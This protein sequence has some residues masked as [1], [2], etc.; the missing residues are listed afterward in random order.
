MKRNLLFVIPS[1]SAG[2]GEKSLVNLLSQINF[3]YYNVDLFLFTHDG[4]FMG[5]LPKEVN[6]IN[7]PEDY[8]LFSLPLLYS[9]KELFIKG[10]FNLIYNRMKFALNNKS[11]KIVSIKEQESWKYISKS[12]DKLERNYDVAIGFLEKTST[13]FCV[14]KVNASKK[15]GW[16]HIDY[17]QLGMNPNYDIK[18]FNKL[19]NIVTVS[20]ECANILRKKFPSQS[21]KI[22]VIYNIVSPSVINKMANIEESLYDKHH[23]EINIISIGRLHYQKGFE[24]AIE[25]CKK[26]RD[27]GF[28][29]KWNIIGDGE[30]REKLIKLIK[31][32]DLQNH[33][34]LLGLKANPYPYIKQADIYVQTSRF[35]GKSIAIDEAKI[36]NKPIVVTNFSTA[37]DQIND[38][39]DGLIVD[40][41]SNS[42]AIGI[43]KLIKDNYLRNNLVHNLSNLKLGTEEEIEKLYKL[44]D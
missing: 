2:G 1:L 23:K 25:A 21:K 31:E 37:K 38:G 35:E 12:L 18:Y 29:I 3:E 42:V 33:F 41:N 7:L 13:Y 4:I 26:L 10:K 32:N 36:L 24:V 17:D 43:E 44:C 27:K 40:M 11:N 6:V 15:I 30:E 28:K 9:I 5:Y 34:K 20:E 14:D 8:K 39:V 16:V 22:E 19:S